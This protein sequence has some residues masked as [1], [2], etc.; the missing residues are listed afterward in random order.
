MVSSRN[1]RAGL[2]LPEDHDV[3]KSGW[4]LDFAS[5]CNRLPGDAGSILRREEGKDRGDLLRLAGA[6]IGMCPSTSAFFS[7]SSR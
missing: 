1:R 3:R 4:K 7:G 2:Q 6:T 5:T